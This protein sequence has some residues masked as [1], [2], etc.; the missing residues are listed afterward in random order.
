MTRPVSLLTALF[1]FEPTERAIW[2]LVAIAGVGTL[3]AAMPTLGDAAI[4]GLCGFGGF[5][6]VDFL[7][8]GDPRALRVQRQLEAPV[9]Q[10]QATRVTR[11]LHG[12]RRVSIELTDALP[13]ASALDG[14]G[15]ALEDRVLLGKDET[16][17]VTRELTLSRRGR[18]RFG[19]VT[20]RTR[21]PLG[22]VRR[23]ARHLVDTELHVL[24]DLARIGARAER[25]LRGQDNDGARRRRAPRE[26][27]EFESLREYQRGDDVR[28]IEWK[29]SARAGALI[30]KRLMP[31]TRQD[32][33][34]LVDTGRQLAGRHED[35]D[36]GEPRLDVAV[37]TAL[38]LA[39]AALSKGDRV[40][41]LAFAGDVRGFSPPVA[42]RAQL[43][44]LADE[45]NDCEVL[46]EE[47]DYG[48]AV[49]FLLARQKRRAL[50]LFLTDVVDEPSARALAAAIA[51]LR[52]R[53]L[54]VVVALGDPALQR[55]ARGADVDEGERPSVYGAAER[56][57][58]HRRAALNALAASG[59]VVVDAPGPLAAQLA[60]HAYLGVK[61]T[62]RL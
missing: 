2:V 26:G 23:R 56:L 45:V 48:E 50:V 51:M 37:T 52:G 18:H 46:P 34:V 20:I 42:G 39:A 35:A 16:V 13:A 12:Q 55:L 28:L 49:R 11:V 19:R 53:H 14:R 7:L 24:P 38:T 3:G 59:A 9:V 36:G 32:V 33:V 15:D 22:L 5:L 1:G 29:A 41:V 6:V 44:R 4:V 27:R 8:A 43:R 31:E 10:H 17:R 61:G 21:G 25:L 57:V 47:A 62:G 30:V 58:A 54:P 60:V 40:G